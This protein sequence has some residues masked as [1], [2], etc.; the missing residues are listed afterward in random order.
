MSPPIHF[1][2]VWSLQ[3]LGLN[4][5]S[6]I[7]DSP[8]GISTLAYSDFMKLLHSLQWVRETVFETWHMWVVTRP[9][10]GH[11]SPK[12]WI[13]DT[14]RSLIGDGVVP[15]KTDAKT[16]STIWF[17]SKTLTEVEATK[18]GSHRWNLIRIRY[19]FRKEKFFTFAL[20]SG[21]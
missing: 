15:W 20:K 9:A 12:R 1:W 3:C 4:T 6:E 13:M 18:F 2:S 7:F 8:C 10:R 17:F 5:H 14:T 19:F 11:F 16:H 21:R